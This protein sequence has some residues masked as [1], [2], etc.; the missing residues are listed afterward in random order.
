M[1]LKDTVKS[2]TT[3]LT[4]AYQ[5]LEGKSATLPENKNIENLAATIETIEQGGATP[6]EI[7]FTKNPTAYVGAKVIRNDSSVGVVYL[8]EPTDVEQIAAGREYNWAG[9]GISAVLDLQF[10]PLVEN[11]SIDTLGHGFPGVNPI[12][13]SGLEH[14]VNVKTIQGEF[15]QMQD[16][17][18]GGE[19]GGSL[20]AFNL[21]SLG[22]LPD[23]VE[24]IEGSMLSGQKTFNE[25]VTLPSKLKSMAGHGFLDQASEFNS[26]I[27]FP[28]GLTQIGGSFLANASKFN[29]PIT[30][31]S[32]VTTIMGSFLGSCSSFNQEVNIPEGVT[33]IG[34]GFLANCK[35]LASKV[36]IPS[37]V[38]EISSSFMFN[39][40]NFDKGELVVNSTLD[41]KTWSNYGDGSYYLG[42]YGENASVYVNGITITG[43]GAEIWKEAFPNRNLQS[44]YRRIIG[45]TD[46]QPYM[47]ITHTDGTS[48]QVK[49]AYT[50]QQYISG[51]Y[52][53]QLENVEKIKINPS[54]DSVGVS[55]IKQGWPSNMLMNGDTTSLKTVEG[56]ENLVSV[57]AIPAMFCVR[58]DNLETISGLPPNITSIN[59]EVLSNCSK[60]NC[61]IEVPDSVVSIGLNFLANNST[62]NQSVKLPASLDTTPENFLYNNTAFNTEIQIPSTVRVINPAFLMACPNFNKPL[63][64]PET[65]EAIEDSF[66]S[67]CSSFNQPLTIPASVTSIGENFMNGCHS[68]N[69]PIT[70]P[71]SV[72]LLKS[73][74]LSNLA[75]MTSPITLLA[76]S[77]TMEYSVFVHLSA[78]GQETGAK[79]IWNGNNLTVPTSTSDANSIL[80]SMTDSA[81]YNQGV[82]ISGSGASLFKEKLP[83]W[84]NEQARNGRKLVVES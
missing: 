63:V 24:A 61:P 81:A 67:A 80:V 79:I 30:I 78:F 54:I 69:Q 76:N 7:D 15:L 82:V 10:S 20:T 36:T 16:R 3:H 64:L 29:Q 8:T 17:G 55:S 5:A 56:L 18:M 59:S 60:L 9:L 50:A 75:A 48:T 39:C 13:V 72:S 45:N 23:N 53:A 52:G 28:E 47:E 12:K 62:F 38:T 43:A 32:T 57:T 44:P 68:F 4:N 84:V 26:P 71:A 42:T 25:P 33:Q 58:C 41:P 66:L 21:V 83:D 22:K 74:F 35:A 49:D 6:E 2:I 1:A 65:L 46:Q 34:D 73:E 11:L 40:N 31:P 70:I 37:T 51:Q 19:E 27:T 14:F 77:L